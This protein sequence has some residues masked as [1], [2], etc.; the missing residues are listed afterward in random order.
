[1]LARHLFRVGRR[2]CGIRALVAGTEQGRDGGE[3]GKRAAR[4]ESPE[5]GAAAVA[6]RLRSVYDADVSRVAHPSGSPGAARADLTQ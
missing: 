1:M 6:G 3:S 4:H 5:S 2:E